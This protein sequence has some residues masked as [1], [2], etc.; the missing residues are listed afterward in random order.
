[1]DSAVHYFRAESFADDNAQEGFL[2]RFRVQVLKS[3]T[4][5]VNVYEAS[6]YIS[7]LFVV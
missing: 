5:T 1:M 7:G 4:A 2:C 6:F 3:V